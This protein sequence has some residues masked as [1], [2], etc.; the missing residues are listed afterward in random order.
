MQT[1][2]RR[3]IMLASV[4]AGAAALAGCSA[5]SLSV[6]EPG[7]SVAGIEEDADAVGTKKIGKPYKVGG[8]WYTPKL[9]E[10]YDKTGK[11]SWY[12]P[13]FHGRRTA[14]GERFDQNAMSAAH[15]TM[16]LP[17]FA[18]VTNVKTGKAVVVRVNDRGPFKRGR[19]IDVS[20]K[21]AEELGFRRAG[22]AKVR[23]E[24]LGPAPLGGGDAE[25]R[26]AAAR[27]GLDSD[28]GALSVRKYLPFGLGK[29][30]DDDPP[31]TVRVASLE[32][33]VAAPATERR[34]AGTAKPPEPLRVAAA[35][36]ARAAPPAAARAPATS[37]TPNPAAAT[38]FREESGG[39]DALITMS[40]AS[41][42]S[43]PAAPATP[44]AAPLSAAPVDPA[45][46]RVASAYALFSAIDGAS[47]GAGEL[48]G[49][50]R[51]A[52]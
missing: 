35:S 5:S 20:K 23:V 6:L 43:G 31:E 4:L 7:L 29:R 36:P 42:A 32:T 49:M 16:P 11:A 3:P 39:I 28:G 38:A 14:N 21:A 27:Y 41:D 52:E 10:S 50:G 8:R 30:K 47:G 13:K 25:T 51:A 24:Y 40:G 18:R 33:D 17:S 46:D 9:D 22:Q 19:I 48:N 12:G 37:P 15:P 1:A 45:Q 26:V 2:I 44:P 34:A